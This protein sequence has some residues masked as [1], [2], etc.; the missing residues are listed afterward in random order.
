MLYYVAI[1]NGNFNPNKY[2][3]MYGYKYA[4]WP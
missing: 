4:K 3:N 2:G 1:S